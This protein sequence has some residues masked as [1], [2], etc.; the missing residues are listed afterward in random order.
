MASSGGASVCVVGAGPSG[1]TALKTLLGAGVTD[2][3]CF[4]AESDI[5]G[6]WVF[7]DEPGHASVYET[8]HLITS[9]RFSQFSDFPMPADYPYFP[10]HRQVLAYL[11]AYAKQFALHAHIELDSKVVAATPTG[12]AWTVEVDSPRGRVTRRFDH[13]VICSGHHWNPFTPEIAARFCGRS[14]HSHEYR[15]AEPFRGERVLVVGGGNS[16]C[17]IAVALEGVAAKTSISM[18]SGQY[19]IPKFLFG[20]PADRVYSRV[21]RL[22]RSW[23][24]AMLGWVLKLSVG[25]Y[26]RYGLPVPDVRPLSIHPTLNSEILDRLVHGLITPRPGIASIDGRKVTFRDGSFDSFDSI[27]WATGYRTSFPFLAEGLGAVDETQARLYLRMLPAS[28]RNLYYIGLIQPNGCIW[29]LAELQA[30]AVAAIIGGRLA[31]PSDLEGRIEA[32]L[33]LSRRNYKPDHRHLIAVDYHDYE[34]KLRRL[35]RA[36]RPA[37]A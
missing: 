23:R 19:I 25:D 11:Q 6:N 31:L 18:R 14:L 10:S 21:R 2:V 15:R 22:P 24:Q 4:E 30:R 20:R 9:R 29:T 3:T 1:L 37:R 28:P 34:R 26:S 32:E 8:A 17:D 16:A 33:A 5:G 35:L 13:L 27:I 12:G 36:V 7:K